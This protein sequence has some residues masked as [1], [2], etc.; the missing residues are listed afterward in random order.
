[1][2]DRA[3]IY[4]FGVIID[5]SVH[6]RRNECAVPCEGEDSVRRFRFFTPL[7]TSRRAYE[8]LHALLEDLYGASCGPDW[9]V[10]YEFDML[11]EASKEMR[12][13]P[14]G[15]LP[16]DGKVD[17]GEEASRGLGAA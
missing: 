11:V 1:M 15:F 2:S 13:C 16:F 8:R 10:F 4:H 14:E 5:G 3:Y 9:F 12:G 6:Y 17:G 7:Q